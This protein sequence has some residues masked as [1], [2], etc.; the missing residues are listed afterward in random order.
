MRI[1]MHAKMMSGKTIAIFLIDLI[2]YSSANMKSCAARR[3][4]STLLGGRLGARAAGQ[5]AKRALLSLVAPRS[6]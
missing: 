5:E 3:A 6:A 1:G 2:A 4:L